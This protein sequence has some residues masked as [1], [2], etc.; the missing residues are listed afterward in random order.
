MAWAQLVIAMDT[1]NWEAIERTFPAH[2]RR[3]TL[4]SVMA[5]QGSGSEVPDPY[6]KPGPQMRAIAETIRRCVGRAVGATAR[7]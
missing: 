3:V 7:T 6:N 4:L 5:E 2:L 1:E